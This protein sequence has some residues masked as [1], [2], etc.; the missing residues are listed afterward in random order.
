MTFGLRRFLAPW[1][2]GGARLDAEVGLHVGSRIAVIG[3]FSATRWLAAQPDFD[4]CCACLLPPPPLLPPHS[5]CFLVC[6]ACAGDFG[7]L[8]TWADG[9]GKLRER[10]L[11]AVVEQV[12]V[13]VGRWEGAHLRVVGWS[14]R[15]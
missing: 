11:R 5:L 4:V 15:L 1:C 13:L 14:S 6:A 9:G 8:G 10:G 12:V 7:G 2:A 3:A